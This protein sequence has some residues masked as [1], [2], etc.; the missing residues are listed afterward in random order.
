MVHP[1]LLAS[2]NPRNVLIIGGAEGAV[3]REV[4]QDT[5]VQNATMV[6]IDEGLVHMC[7]DHL[8]TMHQ[9]SFQSPRASVLFIDGI[10]F[11]HGEIADYGNVL[12]SREFYSEI[13][14]ILR[15]GGVLA[16]Y[17]SDVVRLKELEAVGF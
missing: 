15:P 4:L 9:G 1:A 10:D 12:F 11:S 14:R 5:R 3:L 2:Q 13:H 16:Q 17:M 6:E 8:G 7:R